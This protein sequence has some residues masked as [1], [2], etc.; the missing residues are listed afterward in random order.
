[1][2]NSNNLFHSGE[3]AIIKKTKEPVT[4]AKC[5]YVKHMKKY[6]YIVNENPSTFYFEEELQKPE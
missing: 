3:R 4:I 2:K 1:M 5:Q 6:S